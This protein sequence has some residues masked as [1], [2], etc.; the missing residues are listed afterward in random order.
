M[1]VTAPSVIIKW[2]RPFFCKDGA[3]QSSSCGRV[4]VPRIADMIVKISWNAPS[5]PGAQ[6]MR[7]SD[8]W[9][10]LASL[11]VVHVSPLRAAP[12]HVMSPRAREVP[13]GPDPRVLALAP[14]SLLPLLLLLGPGLGEVGYPGPQSA[15]VRVIWE[16][17]SQIKSSDENKSTHRVFCRS[18]C[19]CCSWP[20]A[21]AWTCS[22]LLAAARSRAEGRKYSSNEKMWV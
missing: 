5:A 19:S 17:S 6:T 7:G 18:S 4:E 2:K 21:A 13:H 8:L 10:P 3:L 22:P 14:L 16:K 11:T 15:I 20:R 1:W 9:W 12:D